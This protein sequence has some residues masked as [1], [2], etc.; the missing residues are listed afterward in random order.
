MEARKNMYVLA[1]IFII[2]LLFSGK[3][4]SASFSKDNAKDFSD[5]LEMDY[6]TD[7]EINGR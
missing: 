2:Y 5:Y 4:S 3:S 6:F 1:I 7:G